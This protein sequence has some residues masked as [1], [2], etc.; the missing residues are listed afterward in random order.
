[1]AE[2]TNHFG[3][4][5]SVSS[6]LHPSHGLHLPVHFQQFVFGHFNI[7]LWLF[8]IEGLERILVDLDPERVGLMSTVLQLCSVGGSLNCS[9]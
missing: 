8:A 5:E 2:T 4:V 9:D 7:K 3:F 1:M 6:H